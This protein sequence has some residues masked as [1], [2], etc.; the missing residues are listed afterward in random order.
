[1]ASCDVDVELDRD[2]HV[3]TPDET[4]S[5]RVI[6][7]AEDDVECE[8]LVLKRMWE[9]RALGDEKRGVE[10]VETLFSGTWRAGETREYPFEVPLAPGPYTYEGENLDVG[11]VLR[12][13]AEI[14]FVD[15]WGDAGF[16]LEPGASD[17]YVP[18][19]EEAFREARE[20]GGA[21]VSWGWVVLGA[22]LLALGILLAVGSGLEGNLQPGTLAAFVALGALGLGVAYKGTR[23][24]LAEKRLGDVRV[25]VS[26]REVEPGDE[27]TCRV[28]LP[29]EAEG[30]LSGLQLELAGREIAGKGG[31]K[32]RNRVTEL[33]GE[34]VVPDGVEGLELE[35][36]RA[37][38]FSARFRIPESAPYSFYAPHNRV[39]WTIT[40]RIAPRSRP[41]WTRE[42]HLVVRPA[43]GGTRPLT[44]T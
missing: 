38:E 9:A 14:G 15:T 13:R 30:T 34:T 3:Y 36:G 21:S 24:Y 5:G 4:L 20:K 17:E 37:E 6:V 40:A 19:D 23:T 39:E 7:E 29:E 42:E 1:M 16:A 11:W 8:A 32:A 10:T 31:S 12:A 27:V 41:T 35:R 22:M 43:A 44:A 2:D 26:P 33:H 28:R 25:R 18:G